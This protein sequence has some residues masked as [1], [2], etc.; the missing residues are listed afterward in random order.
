MKQNRT[1]PYM[2]I[3]GSER[4]PKEYFIV[5][6]NE[7]VSSGP[8]ATNAVDTLFKLH[9]VFNLQF[10]PQLQHLWDYLDHFVYKISKKNS[11][12]ITFKSEYH[13]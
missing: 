2:L 8:S 6:D 10:C 4:D 7:T 9:W 5:I 12:S 13:N 11:V 3:L 1:Q